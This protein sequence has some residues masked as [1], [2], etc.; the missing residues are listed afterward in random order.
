[1]NSIAQFEH[2]SH[3]QIFIHGTVEDSASGSRSKQ[4]GEF[5]IALW[6]L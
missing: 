3:G 2:H 4:E 5:S 1:M 6:D